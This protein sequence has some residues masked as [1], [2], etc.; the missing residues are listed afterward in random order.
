M[1]DPKD[2]DSGK[3]SAPKP[4]DPEQKMTVGSE[5]RSGRVAQDERGNSIWEWQLETGVYSRDVSTQKL[6]KLELNDLSI[7]DSGVHKQ[8]PGLDEKPKPPP[9]PAGG[10]NPY[11]NSASGSGAGFNP[12]DSTRQPIGKPGAPKQEPVPP[13]QRTPAD[14]KK[15]NE[16]MKLK[17]RVQDEKDEDEGK[18]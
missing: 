3:Q 7:A 6:K 12:Y 10:F 9:K 1:S 13:A 18:K 4:A 17:K 5:K 15:L 14:L 11:D 2:K 8:P 16:W